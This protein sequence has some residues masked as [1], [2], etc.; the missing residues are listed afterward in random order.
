MDNYTNEILGGRYK[1]LELVGQGGMARVFKAYD[2]VDDR[3]VALK[4]LDAQYVGDPEMRTRFTN[5]AKA[6]SCFS[7]PNIVNIFDFC[8][9][10]NLAYIVMEYVDGIS[11][12]DYMKAAGT[13]SSREAVHFVIQ[14]LRALQHAHDAGIYHRDI[15]PENIMV[16]PNASVKVSDFGIAKLT[17]GRGIDLDE[18]RNYGSVRYMS[19]EQITNSEIDGRTDIYSVG[20]LL[21]E[22]LTGKLPFES[23]DDDE[24]AVQQINNQPVRPMVINPNIPLGLE[25]IILRAMQKKPADRYSSAAE[26]L[27]DLNEFRKNPQVVFDYV[28]DKS[29][30]SP[31][32]EPPQGA[33]KIVSAPAARPAPAPAPAP[34][35]SVEVYETEEE[36]E[37]DDEDDDDDAP[38]KSMTVP[39]IVAS[40]IVVVLLGILAVMAVK[41]GMFGDSNFNLFG[42]F[43]TD[44]IDVPNFIGM[45]YE[46]VKSQYPD[47]N[48]KLEYEYNTEYTEGQVCG[49][50]PE[51]NSKIG[52]NTV[53]VLK[54]AASSERVLIQDMTDRTIE[55]AKALFEKDGFVVELVPVKDEE[56]ELNTVIYTTP[57][58]NSFAPYGSTVYV[59]YASDKDGEGLVEVPDVTGYTTSGAKDLLESVGLKL[60]SVTE[61]PSTVEQ[62]GIVITQ[63]P[64]ASASVK[65][66]SAIDISI[67]SGVSE[68]ET[69]SASISIRMPSISGTSGTI[70][71]YLN[72][73]LYDTMSVSLNGGV[74]SIS[75]SGSG[76]SNSFTVKLDG[77]TLYSGSI[78]FT[79]SPATV[80]GVTTYQVSDKDYVPSV[81]G[82]T[83]AAAR[84]Q[85]TSAGFSRIKTTTASSDTV[86]AGCVISQT[87]DSSS[88]VA[89]TAS[90]TL[91]ISTGPATAVETT[92]SSA[93]G[94]LTTAG[95]GEPVTEQPATQ[96]PATEPSSEDPNEFF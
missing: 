92:A 82:L 29:E 90:V 25:Q 26:F 64:T 55:E 46:D 60:G 86:P 24:V 57:G 49:Q 11:L 73:E 36:E 85:I 74:Q 33:T 43:Q 40:V 70:Y 51:A 59:Y 80:S 72:G 54:V 1:I 83:E 44:K 15:K 58:K 14:I 81:V 37:E 84:S 42:W 63:S 68:N 76:S 66:G 18:E 23:A 87:P 32:Q 7:H 56:H 5:E 95:S 75:L 20:V 52:K 16:L 3:T 4:M 39:I 30:P 79:T 62:K 38:Q 96:A 71:I 53:I 41:G 93:P 65:S 34:T 10:D 22:L 77:D 8:L 21:Y 94:E 9:D 61:V 78:D 13:L 35:P 69:N 50:E 89:T 27:L 91:V 28:L 88:K 67:G 17:H 19:P 31:S 48:F 6:I 45:M 12:K 47:F 2:S